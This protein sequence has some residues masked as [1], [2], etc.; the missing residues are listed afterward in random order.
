MKADIRSLPM[1]T[2]NFGVSWFTKPPLG[3]HCIV[4]DRESLIRQTP[5]LLAALRRL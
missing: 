3:E 4:V 1:P 5:V 2:P